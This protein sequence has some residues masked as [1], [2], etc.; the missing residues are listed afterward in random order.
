MNHAHNPKLYMLVG[1]PGSGKTTASQAI[2]QLTGAVH[3]WTDYERQKMFRLPTHAQGESDELYDFL[4]TRAE[5]LLQAGTSV[6]FDTN[7]SF[8]ADRDYL[9]LVAE[10]SSAAVVLLWIQVP[11]DVARQR[12][13]HPKHADRN[14]Y[15]TTMQLATFERIVSHLEPPTADENPILIDGTKITA[16]YV[17]SKLQLDFD[18][19]L[20]L[21][22]ELA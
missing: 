18:P 9:R 6:I 8:R 11:I 7:F 1:Y 4:N 17:A 12:A 21:E 16:S 15:D 5:A 14:G 13:I 22:P 20:D 19:Q 10:R 2:H 3:I